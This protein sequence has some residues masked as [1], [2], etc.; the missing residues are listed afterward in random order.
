MKK[1]LPILML[2]IFLSSIAIAYATD[3][4][5]PSNA[6]YPD[7][8][9]N[10]QQN[11][12]AYPMPQTQPIAQPIEQ[13]AKRSE[14]KIIRL[15]CLDIGFGGMDKVYNDLLYGI[16][17]NT[18]MGLTKGNIFKAGFGYRGD[19]Y[20]NFLVEYTDNQGNVQPGHS[21][22]IDTIAGAAAT[23][24][25]SDMAVIG[26][27]IGPEMN[28]ELI[29]S[30]LLNFGFGSDL[31]I[32]FDTGG[33]RIGFGASIKVPAVKF[34]NLSKNDDITSPMFAVVPY[35]GLEL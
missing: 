28:W 10:Y 14:R 35:I 11:Q 7:S 24:S 27:L 21:L 22:A 8:E 15:G 23:I 33:P 26:L 34:W 30:R 5:A 20:T 4:N 16:G 17:V 13:D 3:A 12:Y 6:A 19:M 9:A 31:C 1:K 25:I 2:A 18:I 32:C 29:S